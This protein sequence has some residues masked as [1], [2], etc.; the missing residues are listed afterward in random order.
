MECEVCFKTFIQ[1]SFASSFVL[2]AEGSNSTFEE[3]LMICITKG[4]AELVATADKK[5]LAM[6]PEQVETYLATAPQGVLLVDI[7][8]IREIKR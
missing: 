6:S 8:D 1:K 5:I 4:V 2:I 3:Y 7:L